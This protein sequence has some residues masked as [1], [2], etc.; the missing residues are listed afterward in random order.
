MTVVSTARTV[1]EKEGGIVV[2][3]AVVDVVVNN[4]AANSPQPAACSTHDVTHCG[5]ILMDQKR[6]DLPKTVP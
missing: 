5:H 4:R 2:V 3:V 1:F 6:Q